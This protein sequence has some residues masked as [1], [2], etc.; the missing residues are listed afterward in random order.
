[1]RTNRSM[2][3]SIVIPVLHYSNV[4]VAARWL[5]DV[6]GFKERLRIGTHRIQLTIPGGAVVAAEGVAEA[7]ASV[8]VRVV[9]IDEHHAR[10]ASAGGRTSEPTTHPYGERQY[11]AVDIGGHHWTFSETVDDVDPADWGGELVLS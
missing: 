10:V 11:S 9:G 3:D 7:G 5:C 4:T 6:F 2:P 1:M 8:M